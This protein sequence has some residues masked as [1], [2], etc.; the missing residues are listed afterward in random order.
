MSEFSSVKQYEEHILYSIL[1]LIKELFESSKESSAFQQMIVLSK[2]E[3]EDKDWK[4][5]RKHKLVKEATDK[6][7]DDLFET[8]SE[9]EIK[10]AEYAKYLELKAKF[11]NK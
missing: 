10:K 2:S 9:D 3:V 6:L 8:L 1:L 11:G 5:F 7:I 4:Q